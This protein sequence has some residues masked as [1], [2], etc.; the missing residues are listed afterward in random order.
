M[1][2]RKKRNLYKRCKKRG[3]LHLERRYNMYRLTVKNMLRRGHAD[4]I[5]NMFTDSNKTKEKLSKHF[6]TYIKHKRSAA[7]S[8][9]PPLKRGNQLGT[10][11][12]ERANILNEQFTSV[13][14]KPSQK[15]DYNSQTFSQ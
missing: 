5:H 14:S 8:T 15:I 7:V 13:F 10:S 11:A 9:V 2:I 12:K 3:S 4:Y 1:L 6:W